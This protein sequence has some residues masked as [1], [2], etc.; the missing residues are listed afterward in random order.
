MG[1][2][3]KG[4]CLIN[5]PKVQ[6]LQIEILKQIENLNLKIKYHEKENYFH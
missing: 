5:N 6:P 1:A 3:S 4:D 2:A